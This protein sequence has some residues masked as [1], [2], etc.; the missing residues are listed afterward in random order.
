MRWRQLRTYVRGDGVTATTRAHVEGVYLGT[1]ERLERIFAEHPYLLG[2]RPCLADFGLFASMFRHFSL[3]PTPSRIM[4][5]RAPR[6]YAWVARLWA[7][8]HEETS[9][10]WLAPGSLPEGWQA[11]LED[12]ATGYLP[13][14]HANARAWQQGLR[15]FDWEVQGVRYRR[16]PVVQYRVACRER[17]QDHF[18]GL[19]PDA[20]ARVEARL[21]KLGGWEPLQ[22]D[23]R[24]ASHLHDDL[25]PPFRR[26]P[27]RPAGPF[28]GTTAWNLPRGSSTT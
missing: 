6:T 3:D 27:G 9:G 18:A 22:A 19:P 5:E 16:T 20:Q 24:I 13:Y 8:R 28:A 25:E 14:L 2:G 21:R 15:R 23:G 12:A 17:L 1:L 7:A 11:L 26:G 10:E 4:R